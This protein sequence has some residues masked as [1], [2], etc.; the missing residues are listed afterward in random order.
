[1]CNWSPTDSNATSIQDSISM[2][3]FSPI[4]LFNW[5]IK[6]IPEAIVSSCLSTTIAIEILKEEYIPTATKAT[7]LHDDGDEIH[8][9]MN[10]MPDFSKLWERKTPEEVDTILDEQ[11]GS[12]SNAGNQSRETQHYGNTG[13]SIDKAYDDLKDVPF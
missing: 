8:A 2:I 3:S 13:N 12:D 4:F 7:P 5:G 9:I 10:T 6:F 1:M 11:M